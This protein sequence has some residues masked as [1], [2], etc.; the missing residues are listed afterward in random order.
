MHHDF[1]MR[2]QSLECICSEFLTRQDI[3]I[4]EISQVLRAGHSY[5]IHPSRVTIYVCNVRVE[6]QRI[7]SCS[8]HDI[9]TAAKSKE[10]PERSSI[11]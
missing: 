9:E 2:D 7:R 10:C 8:V 11:A 5:R 4:S 3:S 6:I 1:M